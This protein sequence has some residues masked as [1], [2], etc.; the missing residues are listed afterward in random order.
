MQNENPLKITPKEYKIKVLLVDDQLIV[1][2]QVRRMLSQFDDIEYHFCQD[3]SKALPTA[4][5]IKP[6]LIL[7][8]LI[9][10]D[11]DG[12]TLVKFYR[13]S[14]ELKDVPIIVLSSKEE[15][16]TKA[17]MF[18]AGANDYI[19][20]LPDKIELL[21]RIRYHSKAYINLLQRNEAYESL[22]KSQ[23]ALASELNKAGEYVIS[24][25]PDTIN[26]D[27][28]S[29]FWRFI[30]SA[31]LGGD[32]FGYHWLDENHFAIYLLDVCGHG[33]GPALLS[34]SAMNF[35]KSNALSTLNFH[36]P[37]VVAIA[38]N[39]AFQMSDHNGLYFT[40]WYGVYNK[41]NRTIDYISAG[42]P[43]ALL[44][45]KQGYMS[46]LMNDNFIIGGLPDFPFKA[47]KVNVPESSILY[48][49]SDGVYEIELHDGSI[50]ELD[51]MADFINETKNDNADEIDGLLN[52][53]KILG[54]KEILDDDF[55]M[56]KIK[57]D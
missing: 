56:L 11:I 8:D 16:T 25:L 3:P 6:T 28:I 18:E 20:K 52:K 48:V 22:E 55:S 53:V 50:W 4:K 26:K 37:A 13:A 44:I 35:L 19:V 14:Q 43:P 27:G 40:I 5:E 54:N 34:V 45:D 32:S 7:Q 41:S 23:K 47:T 15:A 46:K 51:E 1:G 17:E 42:H 9:M 38:L 10:P 36:D 12:L 33:V 49:Y 39:K 24:M 30:P 57:F 31:Q 29:T 21:A 2:E